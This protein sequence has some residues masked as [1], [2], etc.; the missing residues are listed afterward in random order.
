MPTQSP[1]VLWFEDLGR[2]DVPRVGGKNPSERVAIKP[3]LL[4]FLIG[5]DPPRIAG[6]DGG[7]ATDARGFKTPEGESH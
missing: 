2:S 1:K 5:D 6:T 7:S 4:L 3:H